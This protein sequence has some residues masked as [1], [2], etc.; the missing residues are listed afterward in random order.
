MDQKAGPYEI[1]TYTTKVCDQNA[2]SK[3][4]D[5][6]TLYYSGLYICMLVIRTTPLW[7]RGNRKAALLSLRASDDV[8]EE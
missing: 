5:I 8:G 6:R 3:Y 7:W 4:K 1:A 2:P